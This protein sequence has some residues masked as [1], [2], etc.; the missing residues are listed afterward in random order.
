LAAALLALLTLGAAPLAARANPGEEAQFVSMINDLR[1]RRGV[2]PVA[3]HGELRALANDWAQRMRDAV[4]YF[5][6][7][8]AQ[9]VTANWITVGENVGAEAGV[10]EIQRAFEASPGHLATL[11]DPRFN[12]V[13]IGV[14]WGPDG[15]IYVVQD[16]MELAES[17]P[18][19]SPASGPAQLPRRTPAPRS[20]APASRSTASAPTAPA[21]SPAPPPPLPPPPPEP[22]AYMS[23]VLTQLQTL[24]AHNHE[25]SVD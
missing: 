4:N 5:H 23:T 16:F 9:R 13:G 22:T 20:A 3:V 7:P 10:V 19:A 6:S 17:A 8:L 1:A 14:A 18:S 12:Y 21:V 25:R 24:D 2:R 15:T 11:V